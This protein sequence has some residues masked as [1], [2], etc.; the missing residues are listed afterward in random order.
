MK[1]S[2]PASTLEEMKATFAGRRVKFIGMTGNVD[3]PIGK[4]W[5]VTN[6]AVWVTFDD[7]HRE[8]FHPE[9]IRVVPRA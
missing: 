8:Y 9:D 2:T 6:R 4:V 3:G 5:R 1:N 7:G